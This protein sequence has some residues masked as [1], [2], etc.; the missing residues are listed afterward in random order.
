[1][2]IAS[3]A[4]PNVRYT[5]SSGGVVTELI[6]YL[7]GKDRISSVISYKFQG[8]DLFV[9]YVAYSYNE[10]NQ[11]GSIYHE[12]DLFPF[13]KRNITKLKSPVLVTCLPCQTRGLRALLDKHGIAYFIIA[14]VCSG[15]LTKEATYDFLKRNKIAIGDVKSLRYRG[16][17]WP[18]GMNIETKKGEHYYFDNLDSDWRYFFHSTIYNANKCFSCKDTFG[19]N[20]DISVADPWFKRY[21]E[22]EKT[23]CSIVAVYSEPAAELVQQM[24]NDKML[25]VHEEISAE[26][27]EKSQRGTLEKK[28]RY[29][30]HPRLIRV[31]VKIY[32]SWWYRRLFLR[33]PGVHYKIHNILFSKLAK[34]F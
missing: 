20:A 32:R 6:K 33:F 31:L 24:I 27:Y 30:E 14:L 9:P 22:T 18:S 16:Y 12:V 29:I 13:I 7:F 26:E 1:M 23:G 25:V 28:Q 8:E 19:V 15:Q 4:D 2:S 10:Y 11:A 3:S 34:I 21:K 17:G 5:G